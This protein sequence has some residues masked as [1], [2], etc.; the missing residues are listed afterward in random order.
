MTV[1]ELIRYFSDKEFFTN[2]DQEVR[3]VLTDDGV[4]LTTGKRLEIRGSQVPEHGDAIVAF[5]PLPLKKFMF[6]LKF[7]ANPVIEAQTREEAEVKA[8][9]MM[10]HVGVKYLDMD[11]TDESFIKREPMYLEEVEE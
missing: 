5:R 4:P 6:S 8:N 3:F 2:M 1:R 9:E 11:I 7:E 10:S